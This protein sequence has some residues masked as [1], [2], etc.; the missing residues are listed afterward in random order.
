MNHRLVINFDELRELKDFLKS[1]K[2]PSDDVK[3][4]GNQFVTYREGSGKILGSGGLEFYGNYCLLR[5]VAVALEF[6]KQ[7]H[8]ETI[9][10]DLINLAKEKSARGIYLLTETAQPFFE[11]LGFRNKS[12]DNAP[13]EIKTSSEFSSVC[14]VSAVLMSMVIK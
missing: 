3:L 1:N 12:R 13:I 11:K 6:R 4:E 14:P 2:L 8:G 9:T 7:G 5:S 10:M